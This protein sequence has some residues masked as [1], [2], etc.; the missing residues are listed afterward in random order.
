M[1]LFLREAGPANAP[2]LV[3]LHGLWLSSAMGQPQIERLSNEYHCLAPDLPEH[4]KSTDIGL[5]TLENTSRVIA[6][7]IRERTPN[8]RA[9]VVGLSLGGSVALGLLRDVPEAVDHLLVSGTAAHLGPMIAQLS[10]LGEPLLHLLKPG[11]LFSFGLRQIN[12]PPPYLSVLQED[13][14]HLEPEAIIHFADELV[15]MEV[16]QRSI[17]RNYMPPGTRTQMRVPGGKLTISNVPPRFATRSR[18][19]CSPRWP[20]NEAD[21]SNPMPSSRTSSITSSAAFSNHSTAWLAWACFT[22]LC[23]ASR[24]MR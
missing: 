4:G 16:P 2:C 12:I 1:A 14:R 7:L 24:A 15:K 13:V 3:F 20:G 11:P 9:H 10:K 8:G 6:N 5:L 17:S 18:I 19:E 23:M 22:V 21:V